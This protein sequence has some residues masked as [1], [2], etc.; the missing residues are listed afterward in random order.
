MTFDVYVKQLPSLGWDV[1]TVTF[2]YQMTLEV[3]EDFGSISKMVMRDEIR[4]L[5][6]KVGYDP[7]WHGGLV[8]TSGG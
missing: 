1:N 8:S 2:P 7:K 6:D 3:D 4:R 5:A